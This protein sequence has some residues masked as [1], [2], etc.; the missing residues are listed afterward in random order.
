[1]YTLRTLPHE[2]GTERNG[3]TLLE[4]TYLVIFFSLISFEAHCMYALRTLPHGSGTDRNDKTLL[5]RTY[6][7]SFFSLTS[8]EARIHM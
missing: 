5:E 1:M 2:S 3:K 6:L 4:R 8:F 7:V